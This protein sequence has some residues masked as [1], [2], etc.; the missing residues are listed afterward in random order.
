[1]EVNQWSLANA[2]LESEPA[3]PART[4]KR[5]QYRVLTVPTTLACIISLWR[6]RGK[7]MKYIFEVHIKEGLSAE[8]YADAWVR[9]SEII[10]RAA[11]W[12]RPKCLICS[13]IQTTR[14]WTY[15][16]GAW[17]FNVS[18]LGSTAAS[19]AA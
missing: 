4:K 5:K 2:R 19:R 9:A 6:Q 14:R 16:E 18:G 11:K 1:M 15:F 12:S 17:T 13:L 10:H 3:V 8:E 7:C